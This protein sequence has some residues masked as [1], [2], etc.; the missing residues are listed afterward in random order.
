MDVKKLDEEKYEVCLSDY[1]VKFV[2]IDKETGLELS[3]KDGDILYFIAPAMEECVL[4]NIPFRQAEFIS[5]FKSFWKDGI[6][7]KDLEE[8]K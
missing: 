4:Q 7:L 2:L 3:D 6:D 1:H 8:I 5:C